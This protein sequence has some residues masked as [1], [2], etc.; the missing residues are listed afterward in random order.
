MQN[1]LPKDGLAGLRAHW[2]NDVLSGFLVFLIALPLCLGIALASGFPPFAGLITALVGGLIVSPMM[3]SPLSIKGP[4]AGLISIAAAAVIDLGHGDASQGYP[5]AVAVVAVVGL[6][7]VLF[8]VL[9]LGKWVDLFPTSA[10]HGMLAAIGIIIISKQLP[11]LL[12]VVPE[13]KKPLELLSELPYWLTHLDPEVATVGGVSLA[14][15]VAWNLLPG[16]FI[17]KIPAPLVVLVTAVGLGAWLNLDEVR[18]VALPDTFIGG[19]SFPDFSQVV[20]SDSLVYI[21]MFTLVGSLESLLT[22]KAVD[23]LD[24]YHRKSNTNKDLVAVGI[25]NTVSGLLGGLPMIAEVVRSSANVNNGA[26]TRWSNFFHGLFLLTFVALLP[27]LLEL[28][29]LSALAALLVFTGFRLAAPSL[30]AL[31][32][33]IG[34]DQ[35][36]VFLTTVILTL[37]EDLLVGIFVGTLVELVL[38]MIQGVRWNELFSLH[39]EKDFFDEDTHVYVLGNLGF[40]NLVKLNRLVSDLPTEKHVV[41]HVEKSVY[42]DHSAME[43]L[44]Q[45][46][47][48]FERLGGKLVLEGLDQFKA[49]SNHE[50]ATRK[51][52]KK[53][54]K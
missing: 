26:K 24:P 4:A 46:Q 44:H 19:F 48:S 20:S 14:L 7:Q 1:E 17:K 39:I 11:V 15:L 37:V 5:L 27:G 8:G 42:I 21:V 41:V 28:I 35:L 50:L 31:T 52:Q 38:Q 53:A 43:F 30:F 51:K 47:H 54:S 10:V 16:S 3:G 45:L 13:G 32:A 25:G 9:R 36:V 22:V 18:R 40:G 49:V 29:P 2:N 12:G 33:R 23:G 6:I 34:W